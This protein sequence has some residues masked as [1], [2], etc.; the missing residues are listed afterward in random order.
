MSQIMNPVLP[1]FNPDPSILRVG[2]D[3][4]IATSTFEWFPGV[5]LFHSKDM[6]NWRQLP[7]PL[8]RTSQLDMVGNP[9]SGGI[10][11]PC[12]TYDNGLFYLLYTD[13]KTR[14]GAYRDTHNY[15][16]VSENIEG[17][18]SEPIY[19]NSS[20]FDPSL[21]H[22]DDGRKWISNR[23]YDHRKG[24]SPVGGIVLQEFSLEQKKMVGPI[25]NIF[26]G[27]E[28]EFTE[29]SHI[30]KKSGYYYLMTA[31]GGTGYNHAVTMARST[32]L[33]G[34]YEVDP[35]NPMLTAK[36]KN[37]LQKAGHACLVETQHGE[38]YIAH[39]VGRPVADQKCILGRETAIQK[40]YW[41]ED[42]WLRIEG[43]GNEPKKIVPAPSKLEPFLFENEDTHDHFVYPTYKLYWS[44]LRRP[45]SEEWISLT[46]RPG[47]LRLIGGESLSSRHRQSLIARRL[48]NFHAEVETSIEFEPENFQQMAG[49]ILYYDTEDYVYL[50]VT[51]EEEKGKCLGIIQSKYGKY[52]ELLSEDN[53]LQD[54]GACKLK[55]EIKENWVQFYYSEKQGEW[56]KVGNPIDFSHLSDEGQEV[57][58]FTGTFVGLAA[59]DLSGQKKFADFDYFDY[60]EI[61]ANEQ[62]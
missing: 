3:Y 39:L 31:E 34:P 33:F 22:D 37:E 1:G 10:W 46:E 55:A 11:A 17:P 6:I 42:G 4:Y 50:R 57:L 12:L 36:P 30:Y 41:S 38:W 20:G 24:K 47:Y 2:D 32:S 54:K 13:V 28:L 52:D 59:Q 26:K 62:K 43:G 60:R 53:K 40:C 23:L 49:L 5:Q 51:Q 16:T 7:H 27:T 21:F 8:T 58:R 14:R 25:H 29:A 15:L 56:K 18:W 19:I 44:S 61:Q 9:D 45:F 35:Q 48:E